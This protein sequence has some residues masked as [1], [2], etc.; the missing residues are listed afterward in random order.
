M[1]KIFWW[2]LLFLQLIMYSFFTPLQSWRPSATLYGV[3]SSLS[4]AISAW[5]LYN[6]SCKKQKIEPKRIYALSIFIAGGLV[7]VLLTYLIGELML[8]VDLV[9]LVGFVGILVFTAKKYVFSHNPE[10]DNSATLT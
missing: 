10:L 4:C 7:P 5:L 3:A 8:L 6:F 1:S 9:L 2:T